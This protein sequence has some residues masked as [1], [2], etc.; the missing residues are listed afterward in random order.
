MKFKLVTVLMLSCG[1]SA[2]SQT[3]PVGTN[4]VHK[5]SS[6][7]VSWAVS[8]VVERG[9]IN[10]A[11]TALTYYEAGISSNKAWKGEPSNACSKSDG[12][13]VSLGDRGNITLEFDY[14]IFDGPGID[15]VVFEN[16]LFSPPTQTETAFVELAFVE[17]SSNGIDFARFPSVSSCQFTNQINSFDAVAWS[18]FK[19]LA[20]IY[21]V[22]YGVPFDLADIDSD[23]VDKTKITTIR[24]IDAVGNID[25]EYASYDSEGNIINDAWPTP[26][27]SCGFDLDAVGVIHSIQ[28]VE[29][30]HHKHLRIYPNPTSDYLFLDLENAVNASI[31]DNSGRILLQQNFDNNNKII[32]VKPLNSGVYFLR[33]FDG[34]NYYNQ[35]FLKI[36]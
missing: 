33:T 21:P 29:S 25:S 30:F 10:I 28:S 5:D 22:F 1:L 2:F 24:I 26:F 36:D 3:F 32:D 7:I 9:Y 12:V 6:I 11:D 4:A 31:I 13:F 14:A 17:V 34:D 19:N 18:Q 15:F 16:A 20:G 27:A 35:K 23:L 8:A